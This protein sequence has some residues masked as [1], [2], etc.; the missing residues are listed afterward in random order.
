ML[1]EIYKNLDVS[2]KQKPQIESIVDKIK[3]LS[4]Q[5]EEEYSCLGSLFRSGTRTTFFSS[6]VE[7]Y[8]IFFFREYVKLEIMKAK[9]Q[10]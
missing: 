7:R 1:S 2:T 10:N 4:R 9:N 6:Q 5:M 3:H 8:A